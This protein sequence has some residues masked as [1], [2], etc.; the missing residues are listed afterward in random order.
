MPSRQLQNRRRGR[1]A[2]QVNV[3]FYLRKPGD[4]RF[5]CLHAADANPPPEM[6]ATGMDDP[7]V[8]V[9]SRQRDGVPPLQRR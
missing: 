7:L 9:G 1:R 8:A 2:D 6:S 4:E 5:D 3:K